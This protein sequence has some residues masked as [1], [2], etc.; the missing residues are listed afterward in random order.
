M[1]TVFTVILGV[2][3]IPSIVLLLRREVRKRREN[4][5]SSKEV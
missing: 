2:I 5:D 4:N 1:Y 3:A